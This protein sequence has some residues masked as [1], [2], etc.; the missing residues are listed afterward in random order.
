MASKGEPK[1]WP[2]GPKTLPGSSS[3]GPP[4]KLCTASPDPPGEP[5]TWAFPSASTSNSL[6]SSCSGS[7]GHN[8]YQLVILRPCKGLTCFCCH[9]HFEGSTVLLDS[10]ARHLHETAVH[11]SWIRFRCF[12]IFG[13]FTFCNARM[14][15]M[16]D[17]WSRFLPS[18]VVTT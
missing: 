10:F 7:S 3:P 14:R 1:R 11:N 4:G 18:R 6:T 5:A 2:C 16:Y 9:A 13:G 8:W 15:W 17:E 12:A